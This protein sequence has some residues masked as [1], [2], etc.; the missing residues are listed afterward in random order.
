M[1]NLKKH[2]RMISEHP[3]LEFIETDGNIK[4]LVVDDCIFY[5]RN[6]TDNEKS[7]ILAEEIA[8][9]QY[10]VGNILNQRI[11]ENKKQEIFA[12]RK[13]IDELINLDD[14]VKCY[15]SGCTNNFEIAEEL[16]VTEEFLKEALE[17][18]ACKYG[19]MTKNG[20]CYI[21][22]DPLNVMEVI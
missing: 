22:F 9:Y 2:E 6:M 17:Y 19:S 11:T 7:C 10:N 20:N 5:N 14:I 16:N 1:S 15:K 3:E 18:F 21:T 8:H 4:G 12:R 13:A